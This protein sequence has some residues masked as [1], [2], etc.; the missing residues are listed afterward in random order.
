M[1]SGEIDSGLARKHVVIGGGSGFVGRALTSFLR[2]R[3]D[4]VTWVSRTPGPQ[5]LTWAD[6]QLHGLP[7]C[8]AVINLAG[9]HILDMRRFWTKRYREEVIASRIR[10]TSTLVDAINTSSRP[11]EV[12]LSSAG[13]CFYGSQAFRQ[14]ELYRDMDE[15][16][17]PVGIDFPAE[18]VSQWE[19]AANA[20]DKD[21]V[22]H[23]QIRLGIVLGAEPKVS[24]RELLPKSFGAYGIFPLLRGFFKCGLCFGMGS[25]V[26]PFP[27]VHID[28]VVGI[29]ARA[30]DNPK[31][32]GIFNA[33]SPG[34]LSNRE[35]SEQ[36]ARALNR[37]FRGQLPSWLIKSAVGLER[38]TILLLGQRIR[39]TRT[40]QFGYRFRYQTISDCLQSLLEYKPQEMAA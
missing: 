17:Q 15:Y 37:G 8:D 36:L 13:K 27:W 3:G 1:L 20:V 4:R 12:F 5:R 2:A 35:F 29:C 21:K 19:E 32:Q 18:L 22:R 9:K 7:E 28:D 40:L 33:V 14:P 39:P 38:S 34:I 10:T 6:I 26:Q 30:I 23:V 25:G 16:S 31:M 11:P 24:T